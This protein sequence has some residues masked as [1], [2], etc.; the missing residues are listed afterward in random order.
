MN[1]PFSKYPK[2]VR[3]SQNARGIHGIKIARGAPSINHLMYA[4]DILLFFRADKSTCDKVNKLLNQFGELASLWMNNQKSKVKF[5]PNITKEGA[6]VLTR[7]LNYRR[8]NHLG[9]YLGD[10]I[11]GYNTAKRIASLILD[12]LQ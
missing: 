12:N 7:I 10:Y 5:S 11:D 6:Q 8:V 2:P 4:D 9:R 3:H 1:S